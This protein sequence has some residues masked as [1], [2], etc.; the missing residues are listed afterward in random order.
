MS[1][2]RGQIVL[3][4]DVCL[5]FVCNF[6]LFLPSLFRGDIRFSNLVL[7][8]GFLTLCVLLLVNY[9]WKLCLMRAEKRLIEEGKKVSA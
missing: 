5:I 6:I 3:L 4:L 9:A 1:R 7:H 2:Y 8:I